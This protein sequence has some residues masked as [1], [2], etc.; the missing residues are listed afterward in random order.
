MLDNIIKK[1]IFF[2]LVIR[3]SGMI[4]SFLL[5][6]IVLG[7]LGKEKYGIWAVVL[8]ITQWFVF[9]DFGMG[10]GLRNLLTKS[11]AK[12]DFEK[13]NIYIITTYFITSVIFICLYILFFITSF[14]LDW[15]KILNLPA[16]FDE[17]IQLF[18][19]I[20]FGFIFL[21]FIL[22]LL[23]NIFFA[24]QMPAVTNFIEFVGQAIILILLVLLSKNSESSILH[25]GIIYTA[26]PL[27][28]YLIATF[29]YFRFSNN[30]VFSF[31]LI[32]LSFIK[33]IF[34]LGSGFL[35]MQLSGIVLTLTMI[36]LINYFL[37]PEK[38][39]E[40]SIA[41]K[42]ISILLILSTIIFQ[43]YWSAVTNAFNKKEFIWIKKALRRN[44]IIAAVI[45]LFSLILAVF[46]PYVFDV[47]VK[48]TT[49]AF[50]ITIWVSIYSGVFI[51]T[52]PIMTFINGTGK[53]KHQTI[54]SILII[55]LIIPIQVTLFKFTPLEIEA[56]LIPPILFRILRA[57]LGWFQLREILQIESI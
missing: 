49:V 30:L 9:F 34:K 4:I 3:G 47:W 55:V 10:N 25:V 41:K 37:G 42:Y 40:Y 35:L 15:H 39:T 54:Y 48:G 1:N 5:L 16:G 32:D 22:Q 13:G 29:L 52:Q 21:R 38:T 7:F 6:P 36:F 57:T 50:D 45:S 44:M 27:I 26:T 20:V 24:F 51:L 14:F 19:Q 11:I 31:N 2:G 8:S 33:P 23:K 46:S 17:N 12:K 28:V 43:P 18:V 56:F 53:I